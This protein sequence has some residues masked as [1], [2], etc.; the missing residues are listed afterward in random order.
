MV[1]QATSPP[2]ISA[3]YGGFTMP[4]TLLDTA[5]ESAR[6]TDALSVIDYDTVLT[7][8]RIYALQERYRLQ[9]QAVSSTIYDTMLNDGRE[10]IRQNYKNLGWIIGAFWYKEA[11]LGGQIDQTLRE[12]GETVPDET[13]LPSRPGS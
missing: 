10:G 13:W 7:L 9:T 2:E 5:W 11:E 1:M 4:A 12:I 6:S 8:A 3:F